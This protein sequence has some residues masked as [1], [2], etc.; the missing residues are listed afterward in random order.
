MCLR[1]VLDAIELGDDIE[2]LLR[3]RRGLQRVEEVAARMRETCGAAP[4]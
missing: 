1:V 3:D 4:A 2:G